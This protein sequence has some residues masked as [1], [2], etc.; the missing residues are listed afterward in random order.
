MNK[1]QL[2]FRV[3]LALLSLTVTLCL[4]VTHLIYFSQREYF[5]NYYIDLV[6]MPLFYTTGIALIIWLVLALLPRIVLKHVSALLLLLAILFWLQSDIFSISYGVLDGSEIDFENFDLRGVWE[7]VI[8]AVAIILSLLV[9]QLINKHLVSVVALIMLGQVLIAGVNAFNEPQDKAIISKVDVE[10][11]NYSSDKN[12]IIIVL[13]TFGGNVFQDILLKY[14]EFKDQYQGFVSYTDAIS[15]YPA[16]KGS[17]PSLLTGKMIPKDI[18]TADFIENDVGQKG[19]PAFYR[20]KGYEVSVISVFSWFRNFFPER[21]M[22]EPPLHPGDLKKYNGALLFDYSLFRFVPHYLKEV[23]YKE[24]NWLVSSLVSTHTEVPSTGP[25]QANLFLEM[26]T[27][28]AVIADATERFKLIHVKTPHPKFVFDKACQKNVL[29]TGNSAHYYMEQQSICALKKLGALLMKY[30]EMGL[31][32]NSL[33]VVTSDHGTRLFND[34]SLTGFPS[35]FEMNSAGIMFMIKGVGQND[36]FRQV[37]Q[38]FS[39]IKLFD[40]LIDPAKHNTKYDNLLDLNRLFYA[41][42]NGFKGAPKMMQDAPLYQV[43]ADYHNNNSWKLQELVVNGCSTSSI[44]IKMTFKTNAREQYCGVFGFG[45]AEANGKGAWTESVDARIVFN[46]ELLNDEDASL[47]SLEIVF[48]P[49]LFAH[50]DQFNISIMLND[51]VI[52]EQMVNNAGVQSITFKFPTEFFNSSGNQV[53]RL[54]MPDI[55]SEYEMGLGRNSRVF[56][57]LVKSIDISVDS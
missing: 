2:L 24:G 19:L 46:P 34:R 4:Y 40:A 27:D 52:G 16:T 30:K 49:K 15:N 5:T 39:L 38:P 37:N 33:I 55:K 48:E 47:Y 28:K 45:P 3:A 20:D 23:V 32:D 44:P 9:H 25:E 54:S 26:M 29:P 8:L 6:S 14:P 56:G 17:L 57:I 13:D 50:R 51:K 7:L 36:Q 11:F 1:K 12:I 31:Y 42:P 18:E 43:D 35:Y 53:L 41:F 22:S 10:F 21:F